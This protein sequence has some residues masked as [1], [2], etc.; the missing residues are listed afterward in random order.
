ML[1]FCI[2]DTHTHAHAHIY[3]VAL[4]INEDHPKCFVY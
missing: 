1:S 4:K 3:D 2:I